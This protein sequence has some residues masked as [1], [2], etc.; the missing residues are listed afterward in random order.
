MVVSQ[1]SIY[2]F[3]K[4]WVSKKTS[5]YALPKTPG[6]HVAQL[7][8]TLNV[9]G[10]ITGAEYIAD[11]RVVVLT[12]YSGTV[13]PFIYLLYD[14]NGHNFFSG[15]KR[16]ISLSLSFHQT[17]GIASSNG[18]DYFITNE[19]LVQSPFINVAQKLHK[20]SL[21]PY[22]AN[23]VE[24][25]ALATSHNDLRNMIRVYPN[26]AGDMLYIDIDP[27]LVGTGYS[28]LDMNAREA[29]SGVLREV[30]N[31]INISKLQ[32]GIYTIKVTVYPD[33]SYRLVKR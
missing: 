4:Q 18:L 33:Y 11:R 9:N 30:S 6:T 23:Y 5:L 10:L 26:P 15:N 13:Q 16:K 28:L 21:A 22:L 27:S 32:S 31:R 3:T 14:F 25:M 20:V 24:N 1:D 12:G 2:L 17:E 8:G 19:K 7:K 29:Q